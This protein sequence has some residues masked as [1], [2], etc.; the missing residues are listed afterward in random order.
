MIWLFLLIFVACGFMFLFCMF[1]FGLILFVAKHF[2]KLSE[3]VNQKVN[4]KII[5]D[6]FFRQHNIKVKK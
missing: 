6:D 1:A 3:K 2:D 4:A 5:V